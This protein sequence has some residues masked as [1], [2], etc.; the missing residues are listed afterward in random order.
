M[1][2][3]LDPIPIPDLD[4]ATHLYVKGADNMITDTLRAGLIRERD[5]DSQ[6][7]N[8]VDAPCVLVDLG[9]LSSLSAQA[10]HELLA[11]WIF[12]LQRQREEAG[13]ERIPVVIT[14]RHLDILRTV[15][16]G[17]R[18]EVEAF[19]LVEE[20]NGVK[21]LVEIGIRPHNSA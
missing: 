7:K 13:K 8:L 4:K 1:A 21:D 11:M 16:A 6:T 12:D 14:A 17:L 2:R 18:G 20:P 19:A 10:A 9:S 5:L 15:H 3:E